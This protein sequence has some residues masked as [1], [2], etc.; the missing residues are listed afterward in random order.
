MEI[1]LK[2]IHFIGIGGSG[3]SG[4]AQIYHHLGYEVTGSDTKDSQIIS[5]L[6]QIGIK[7]KIKHS[8]SNVHRAEIVVISSAIKKNN[9][10]LKFAKKN[11]I[12]VV[13]RAKMLAELLRFK[14]GI[15]VAGSH[16]K[17]TTTSI[18]SHIFQF[19]DLNPTYVIGGVLSANNQ[20]S[21]LGKS[22]ILVCE[23]DES[24]KSFLYLNPYTA[25][26]TNIDNDHLETYKN[27]ID[28][29]IHHF[30]L[31]TENL[32]FYGYVV[33][34]IDNKNIKKLIK[35]INRPFL[36]Y[37]FSKKADYVIEN[38]EFTNGKPN[39]YLRKNNPNPIGSNIKINLNT[40]GKHNIYNSVGA[41]IVSWLYKITNKKIIDS[42]KNFGGVH[43]RFQ[44]IG[45]F[46]VNKFTNINLIDD[47]GH[48]PTELI[49]T[50]STAKMAFPN[51]KIYIV[52]QPHRYS[53]TKICFNE[54]V[55]ALINSDKALLTNIYSAGEKKI[56]QINSKRIRAEIL[57]KRVMKVDVI[58]F[59]S[60]LDLCKI[61]KEIELNL[62]NN[63]LILIMG[64][65]TISKL[66]QYLKNA[67][68]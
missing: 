22:D 9:V 17:T 23:A 8:E 61:K 25:V 56:S 65:G 4:L 34:N 59:D 21:N 66:P 29:L 57:K 43:R 37:G 27:S 44:F 31:F 62:D 18:I 58:D 48:H 13:P 53:R 35:Y 24:D 49:E 32:P 7:I 68:Q 54:F 45:K 36:T 19:S 60:D 42:L 63:D 46:K 51:S 1:R 28:Y 26:I 47:Y 14:K 33:L 55:T 12:P 30:Y 52:F 38:L 10:E 3:M 20:N 50:I 6:K 11:N 16:G 15:A 64:A 39:F 2:K 41:I 40:Y 67:W 5:G